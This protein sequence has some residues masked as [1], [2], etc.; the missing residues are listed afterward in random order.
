MLLI[1]F[2]PWDSINEM[3]VQDTNGLGQQ[4]HLKTLNY[5]GVSYLL[6]VSEKQ[7]TAQRNV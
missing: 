3:L 1:Y 6:E 2:V 5:I 7:T 4:R